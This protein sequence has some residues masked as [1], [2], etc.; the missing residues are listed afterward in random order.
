M[1]I[2]KNSNNYLFNIKK[3]KLGYIK[4]ILE[5]IIMKGIKVKKKKKNFFISLF[6]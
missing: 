3:I 1:Y 5:P 2:K 4:I 6:I